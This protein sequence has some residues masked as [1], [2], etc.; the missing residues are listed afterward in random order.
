MEVKMIV[1]KSYWC[2]PSQG[3][4][5]TALTMVTM[6][7]FCKNSSTAYL[8]YFTPSLPKT[9]VRSIFTFLCHKK[10]LFLI[11]LARLCVISIIYLRE[12]ELFT[13][14]LRKGQ[15]LCLFWLAASSM[16]KF[17]SAECTLMPLKSQSKVR[18]P[19][20]QASQFFMSRLSL[21]FHSFLCFHQTNKQTK[22]QSKNG[23]FVHNFAIMH[24]QCLPVWA[25]MLLY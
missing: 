11:L 9:T 3:L 10:K 14:Y 1:N 16:T 24:V 23:W 18:R 21:F 5:T 7:N 4:L 12:R 15:T 13:V 2:L 8:T 22:A 19:C 17:N 25:W 20:R 6:E